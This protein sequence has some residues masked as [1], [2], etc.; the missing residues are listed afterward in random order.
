MNN[1]TAPATVLLIDDHPMIRTGLK[2]LIGM[3]DCLEVIGEAG[4]GAE[5]VLL[6]EKNDYDLILLDLHMP[7]M[8]GLETLE[9]LRATDARGR[10][11]VFS[12]SDYEDDVVR[13]LKRGAD[14]YLLKD[15][16]PEALLKSLHRAAAGEMVLSETLPPLLAASLRQQRPKEQPDIERLTARERGILKLVA[17]GMSNKLIARRL[18]ISESTVKVH[19][20]HLLKKL[21][22]KSRVEAAV[23]SLQ[24]GYS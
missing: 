17:M 2:Q 18:C 14:G 12:V 20:K 15:M 9:Q 7:G 3:D 21:Q 11:V 5:G 1:K 10:I 13:A 16:E 4:N 24:N 23:W 8:N 6:A 19:V 22:M